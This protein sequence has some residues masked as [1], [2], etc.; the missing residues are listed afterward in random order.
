V[1]D[2]L[3]ARGFTSTLA[4]ASVQ[5]ARAEE[6]EARTLWQIVQGVTAHARSIPHT[7]ERVDLETKAG[8]LLETGIRAK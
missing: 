5:A 6:G 7:D 4:K 2:W 1:L 3:K 8:K